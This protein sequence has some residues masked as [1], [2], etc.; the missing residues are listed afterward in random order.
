MNQKKQTWRPSTLDEINLQFC[1]ISKKAP[2]MLK[3]YGQR[4][5]KYFV[6]DAFRLDLQHWR[7]RNQKTPFGRLILSR[8]VRFLS[9]YF[10]FRWSV[11]SFCLIIFSFV[12]SLSLVGLV[13]S[14]HVSPFWFC[15]SVR[16]VRSI[17]DITLG[18]TRASSCPGYTRTGAAPT[19]HQGVHAYQAFQLHL[20]WRRHNRKNN[21]HKRKKAT[22][23]WQPSALDEISLQFFCDIQ[24]SPSWC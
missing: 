6:C 24:K 17:R 20:D 5:R 14:V 8:V 13:D 21:G 22:L 3:A 7:G 9:L 11:W 19:L 23:K 4:T 10:L 15:W 2:P 12:F 1:A 16:P 18:S